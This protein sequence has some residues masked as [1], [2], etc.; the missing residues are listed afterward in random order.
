MRSLFR[1]LCILATPCA[2]ARA[3]SVAFAAHGRVLTTDGRPIA[4]ATVSLLETLEEARTDSLGRF[5]LSSTHRGLATIVARGVGYVPGTFD[6]ALPLDSALTFRLIARPATLSNVIVIAAGEYTIGTGNTASLSPLDVAQTPGAAANIARAIQTLPGAQG[7]DEGTGLFVRGGDVMETRVLVD[8]AWLLSPVRF[9]NPT[10]HTTTTVNPFLL[11]RTVF[12]SGGFG[13]Q[14]GNALSG[15]VRMESA[16]APLRTSGSLSA[17]IGGVNAAIGVRPTR[18]LGVR[19]AAGVTSLAALTTVFGEAQPYDPP[20]RGGDMSGTV[21]W[22]TGPSGRVRLF[23][24]RQQSKFGVGL[25]SANGTT[26]YAAH[27]TDGLAVLTWRD[28]STAWRPALTAAIATFDRTE[29]FGGFTLRTRLDAPQLSASLGYRTMGGTFWRAGVEREDLT[30]SYAGAIVV[31]NDATPRP[32]FANHT[33]SERVG[34]FVEATHTFATGVRAIAGVR[35]DKSTLTARRTVDPRLSL[36]WQRGTLGFTAAVG[37]YHQVAEPTFRRA[38]DASQFAPM[39][40]TQ[41][42]VGMQWGSDTAG[43]R[44]EVFDKRYHDLWQFSR[45]YEPVGGGIG[46]SRGTD[47]QWRWR[48]TEATRTRIT[49]SQV[50]SRR[51]DASTGAL[52]PSIADISHSFAWITDHMLHGITLGGSLRYATGRPFT[53]VTGVDTIGGAPVPVYGAPFGERMPTYA[54][55]DLS[56]SWYRALGARRGLV[57]WGSVSNVLGRDNVMRYRWTDDYTTRFPVRAPFLRSVFI[58]STLLL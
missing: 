18:R 21:E 1:I 31:P 48:L 39:R 43:L 23:A 29:R 24:I 10:G 54:R 34:A 33:P 4:L 2:A 52:A 42:I 58:G 17:S 45:D 53:D 20:P 5:A 28:S 14:Y 38:L 15:L 19:A 22:Q 12:S 13:A 7:V 25:A 56:A 47:L 36:A 32:T 50:H 8:D 30:A 16:S 11:D 27:S 9:D 55:A 49:W 57:L 44:I 40:V 51:T 26:G 37:A 6:L 35:S 41:A 3:Q 46:R